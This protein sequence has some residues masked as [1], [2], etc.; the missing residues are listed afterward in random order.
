MTLCTSH[1][2]MI[3]VDT[4]TVSHIHDIFVVTFSSSSSLTAEKEN[5]RKFCIHQIYNYTCT[6]IHFKD[7]P[8]IWWILTLSIYKIYLYLL[9]GWE[10]CRQKACKC[11]IQLNVP[12]MLGNKRSSLIALLFYIYYITW[13]C[14]YVKR[15]GLYS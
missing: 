15:E 10:N 14:Y 3:R 5:L 4:Y 1:L 13:Y 11:Q 2:C 7:C 8:Y 9:L 6:C 12:G